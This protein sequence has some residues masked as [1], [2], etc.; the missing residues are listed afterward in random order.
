M[1]DHGVGLDDEQIGHVFDRF[2]RASQDRGDGGKDLPL[3]SGSVQVKT[4]RSPFP[5]RLVRD[6]FERCDWFVF[7]MW[8]GMRPSVSIDGY[9]SRAALA[10][11]PLVSSPRGKWMNRQIHLCRLLH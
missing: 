11:M 5:T 8:N 7:A 10:Q 3:P 2:W 4:S 6:P 1:R 9:V